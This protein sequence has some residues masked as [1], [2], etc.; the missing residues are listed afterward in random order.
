MI[1]TILPYIAP[2]ITGVATYFATRGKYKKDLKAMEVATHS[3]QSD[4]VSKNLELYQNMLDDI[5]Q[6]YEEQIRKRDA[7]ISVLE[8][9][10]KE[11]NKLVSDLNEQ[12]D[13][14]VRRFE[15]QIEEL[16]NKLNE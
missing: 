4:V 16:R 8:G 9:K 6:R 13:D 15:R 3:N 1:E 12:Q 5:E 10:V 11:L 14:E 2:A 7:Q